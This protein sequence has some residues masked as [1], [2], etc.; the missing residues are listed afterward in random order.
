MNSNFVL[1]AGRG[2]YA[3]FSACAVLL[4]SFMFTLYLGLWL[5]GGARFKIGPLK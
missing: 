4:S 1:G 3:F 2:I 5:R